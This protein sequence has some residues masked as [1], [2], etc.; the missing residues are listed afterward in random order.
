MNFL[1]EWGLFTLSD[2]A[3]FAIKVGL[4][5]SIAHIF[6]LANALDNL[7]VA[8]ITIMLIATPE[9]VRD[10][11]FKGV[12]RIGGT[13]VG[14]L[15]GMTLI[16]IFPQQPL[17]YMI[18]LSLT[19]TFILYLR[20]AY[21]GDNT[22]FMLGAMTTMAM[23]DNGNV[24]NVFTYGVDRTLI[25][26][27]AIAIYTLVFILVWPNSTLV[28]DE[29][30]ATIDKKSSFVW[31]DP[32]HLK[33][34][35]Q[36][37]LVFWGATAIWYYLNPPGGFMLVMLSTGLS[38]LTSYSPVKPSVMAILIN[39]S[40]LISIIIYIFV[41]PQLSTW[42]ELALVIFTYTFF[43]FYFFPPMLGVLVLLGMNTLMITNTMSYNVDL[44]LGIILLF[45]M[46]LALLMIAYYIPFSTKPEHLYRTMVK[47]FAALSSYHYSSFSCLRWYA[48]THL[49]RTLFK[50][51]LWG[52]KIDHHTFHLI[53]DE[54]INTLHSCINTL[55][56]E[57]EN[58][59]LLGYEKQ[60]LKDIFQSW[61][62]YVDLPST[63]L[64]PDFFT[65]HPPLRIRLIQ[66][67]ESLK[68]IDWEHLKKGR[69]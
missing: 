4:S 29:P 40:L 35:V 44:F 30:K 2:K 24:D 53:D 21:T 47:R 22:M 34:A 36:T 60:K 39:I 32:E 6:V 55:V 1:N 63:V 52:S 66:C 67:Q 23:F 59:S 57:L 54:K 65:F 3:K 27:M 38:A 46:F 56:Q 13:I 62:T 20:N 42:V 31:L 9:K 33:G 26:I 14:A 69:F 37:F 5:M 64:S 45:D 48:S 50:L 15:I 12:L 43:A 61:N 41:L 25:T 51:K 8:V 16:V 28:N 11:I 17:Y 7:S 68:A 18:F 49:Y 58:A 19:V 10:A